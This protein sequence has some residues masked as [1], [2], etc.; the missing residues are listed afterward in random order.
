MRHLSKHVRI[1]ATV[2]KFLLAATKLF[3]SSKAFI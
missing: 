1:E 2:D 3:K